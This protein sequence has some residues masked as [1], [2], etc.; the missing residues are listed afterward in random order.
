MEKLGQM[1][2]ERPVEREIILNASVQ[3]KSITCLWK[4]KC[5]L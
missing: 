4:N 3:E 5:F 1:I 2:E